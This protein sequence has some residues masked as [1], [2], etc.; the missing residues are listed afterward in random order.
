MTLPFFGVGSGEIALN[1]TDLLANLGNAAWGRL[2][3]LLMFWP[4]LHGTQ[5]LRIRMPK[6]WYNKLVDMLMAP[7]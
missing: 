4:M 7:F 5:G 3:G 6:A 2:C 1:M